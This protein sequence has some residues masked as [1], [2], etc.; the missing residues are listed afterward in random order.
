[1]IHIYYGDGK[2]KTTAAVGL[3]ARAAGN[4]MRVMFV[5]FL[6]TDSS[7]ERLSLEKLDTVTLTP[8][9]R[10]LKFTFEMDEQ[11]KQQAANMYRGLF[12][13]SVAAALAQRFDMIIFDEIFDA[14]NEGML[15]EAEVFEFI[16]NAPSSM[17][18]VMTGHDPSQRFLEAADY[19]TEFK[20]IKHP[21]D[22]GVSGR[23][24]I[25]F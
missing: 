23:I 21:F 10:E 5:Q 8:C 20:K 19:V 7:G 3:A 16:A 1:M 25:E 22:S 18:I 4:N 2:G 6:K 11:E 12:D 24:G 14:V 17:E 15:N 9:P 13:R